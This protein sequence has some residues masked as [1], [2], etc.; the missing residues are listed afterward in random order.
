MGSLKFSTEEIQALYEKEAQQHGTRPES[1]IQD[2]R[3]RKLELKAVFKYLWGNLN[4][5]EVG[6]GNG[7]MASQFSR[8]M[9]ID[10]TA[11]DF[12]EALIAEARKQPGNAKFLVADVL[13]LAWENKFDFVY[14]VRCLQNLTSNAD[15]DKALANIV[16]AL[17]PGGQFAMCEGFLRGHDNRN[18]AREEFGL[19]SIP[20]P[21]HNNFFD[22]DDVIGRMDGWLGCDYLGEDCFLSSYYFGKYVEYP[23]LL[24]KGKEPNPASVI[25][26]YY[27]GQPPAGDFSPEKILK[28]KKRA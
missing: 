18:D 16:R 26:D 9:K 22:Q 4:V 15:Q 5:L 20:E 24:P 13:N 8:Q 7:W 27:C 3:T 14:S 2:E 19:P 25:L 11:F 23:R 6:C 10:I 21:W 17:K 1:T 12:S 28:F